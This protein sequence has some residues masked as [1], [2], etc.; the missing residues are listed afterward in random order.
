MSRIYEQPVTLSPIPHL[1]FRSRQKAWGAAGMTAGVQPPPL[2]WPCSFYH[3]F[4]IPLL[5]L[6]AVSMEGRRRTAL[7]SSLASVVSFSW[8]SAP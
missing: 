4:S 3:S 6:E 5:A 7:R 2:A 8:L 1:L